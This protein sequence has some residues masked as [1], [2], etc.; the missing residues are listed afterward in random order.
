VVVD[1][2]AATTTR[3]GLRVHDELDHG[4]YATRVKIPDEQLADLP[5]TRHDF[6]GEWNSTLHPGEPPP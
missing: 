6:H 3:N 1:L 2:I 5:L 4:R